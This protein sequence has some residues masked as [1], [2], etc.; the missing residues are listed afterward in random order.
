MTIDI[1]FLLVILNFVFLLIVLNNL[2]YKPL[3]AFFA[4]RQNQIKSDVEEASKSVEQ[5]Q[6]L[7]IE[8]EDELKKAFVE[9]RNIKDTIVK[10]AEHHAETIILTARK[11]EADIL[12]DR[13]YKIKE[14]EKKAKEELEN[15]ISDLIVDLAS[16]ILAEKIDCDKDKELINSLLTKRGS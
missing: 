6:L 1:S 15:D 11:N 8:K 2:L 10:E 7:V 4:D 14:L 5:A 16:K 12:A 9:A 3:K 13:E